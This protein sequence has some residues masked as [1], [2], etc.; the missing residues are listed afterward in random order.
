MQ[1][2]RLVAILLLLLF[3]K[4]VPAQFHVTFFED[5]L[6]RRLL[7]PATAE[8][9]LHWMHDLSKFYMGFNN[10]LSDDYGKQM[11][12]LAD[13]TRDRVLMCKANLNNADRF[14]SFGIS[15][16]NVQRGLGYCQKALDIARVNNLDE[17]MIWSYLYLARGYRTNGENDKALTFNNLAFSI[18]A[19]LRN[20]SQKV[21][22]YTS[23]GSTY[24]AKN[25]K[26]LAF[27]NFL[28]A[29][30]IAEQSNNYDLL[31]EG[32]TQLA[33]FYSRLENY[34]KA[35]DVS[36]KKLAMQIKQQKPYDLLDT[37]NEIGQWYAYAGQEDLSRKYYEMALALADTLRF[38]IYKITSYMNIVNL[39]LNRG[40]Y[41]Q[42]LEYFKEH[43][44]LIEFMKKAGS[45][46]IDQAYGV[47]YDLTNQTDSA[48][49]FFERAEPGVE[50]QSNKNNKFW[51]Y[52]QYASFFS[53]R[54]Y[55]DRAI[56]YWQKAQSVAQ[57][58][59]NLDY[60]QRTSRMLDSVYQWKQDFRTAY[61]Y[62][63]IYHKY[64]DSAAA[65]AKE[66]D[67]LTLEIENENRRKE[68]A[69]IL[70]EEATRK[71]HN[72]Q[73]MAITVIMA[74]VFV[75]LVV[76]GV[77]RVSKN[78][79]KILGFFAFIFF[80]EFI[81]LLADNLIHGWTH[82]EPWKVLLIKIG[83]IAVLLPLHHKLEEKVI[84]YLTS[85][86]MLWAKGLGFRGKWFRKKDADVPMGNV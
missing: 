66:K 39:Y 38:G 54:G 28:G 25:E 84:H 29:M 30:D 31:N 65:L 3:C 73:Y 82:G 37:Y 55:Y 33:A 76:A 44:D 48:R 11:L 68:R 42:G 72:I 9:R 40:Q 52:V 47:M 64:K 7:Q 18:A 67:L 8:E 85:Q 78:T 75:L 22:L 60:L 46:M 59:G 24:L 21:F 10:E 57:E 74:G 58:V 53:V 16:Q 86:D 14:F 5:S 35:K 32:Y 13:S 71:R 51:F 49:I 20:D 56:A 41:K 43:P 17:Y 1:V 2:Q 36:F 19:D 70:E 27:R 4:S 83:L 45:Y 63:V 62:S 15:Q 6:K 23:L 12:E 69:A 80:F 50:S 79:I 34:E 81:I 77:F 26:L 61:Q